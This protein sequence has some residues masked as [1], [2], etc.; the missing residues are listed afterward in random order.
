[1]PRIFSVWCPDGAKC[2]KGSR[3]LAKFDSED[4]CRAA[5][6]QH[7]TNS[8][9]HS[10][11]T[12]DEIGEMCNI[13]EVQTWDYEEEVYAE[14]HPFAAEPDAGERVLGMFSAEGEYETEEV[15][16][17]EVAEVPT[18]RYKG[19]G[20]DKGNGGDKGKG[21]KGGKGGDKGKKHDVGK[22][23]KGWKNSGKKKDMAGL[24]QAIASGVSQAMSTALSSSSGSS[25]ALSSVASSRKSVLV[26]TA[27]LQDI[28]VKLRG[29]EY[30]CRQAAKV[31]ST[32]S[33]GFE[34]EANNIAA[35][36][37]EVERAI[38]LGDR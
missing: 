29:A 28:V 21:D 14:A 17:E 1:M 4:K 33:T 11:L 26:P 36:K 20:G 13:A 25:S 8:P 32:A 34:T 9:Y 19:G 5:V 12:E 3:Q 27:V 2:S 7:L 38:L 24:A 15:E 31:A 16:D 10:D 35:C 30:N 37:L 22:G 6:L 23:G 18:K